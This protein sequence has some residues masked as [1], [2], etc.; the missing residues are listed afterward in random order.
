MNIVAD[1]CSWVRRNIA[2]SVFLVF[3]FIIAVV[4]R[5]VFWSDVSSVNLNGWISFLHS[6]IPLV[7]L[8]IAPLFIFGRYSKCFYMVFLCLKC[9]SW[10]SVGL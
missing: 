2:I 10:Q 5:L 3:V 6:I 1:M 8:L 7:L 9:L 4:D